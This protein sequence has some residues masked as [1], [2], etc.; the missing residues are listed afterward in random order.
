MINIPMNYFDHAASTSLYPEV[1]DTL[2]TSMRT[3]FAN[4]SALHLLGHDLAEKISL[5]KEN[6]LRVL[7]GHKNDS[8]I[9][10]SSAT[11]SNNTVIKGLSFEEGDVVVYCRADHPSV[12]A[13]VENLKGILLREIVLNENGT[14][15]LEL[16][17][18]LIDEKVKLVVIT[19]VNNQS[20]VFLDTAAMSSIAKSQSKAHVHIDAVQSFGKIHF[21]VTPD[22]D[23]VSFTSHKI[24]GPKGI[25]GLFLK[26]GHQVKPLLLGGGQESGVRSSTQAYPLISGFHQA[27]RM[28]TSGQKVSLEQVS[29]FS[30]MIKTHLEKTI[31]TIMMP[32][33]N[34][35]PYI[36]SFI[37][38]GISSDI[39]LRHLEMRE[40]YISSTSACSSRLS[41]IN[42]TLSAMNIS[43]R[44]HKNF[45][46]ISLGPKTTEK[47]VQNLLKEFVSV[48]DGVKHMQK[49]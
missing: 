44:Y 2:L 11:E 5:Y 15:D 26:N 14:V 45:L 38:P 40:V 31:P 8:F 32:F 10:T 16:F 36:V 6:F 41:G 7:G 9:F 23:S 12:T 28:A 27:M 42:P 43:E 17:K 22:I 20:G 35:S 30:E 47:E 46:R 49:R 39:I 21:K 18:T 34:T 29:K 4:P 37:L 24:G 48:W 1:L 3:D 25:A 13:P 19:S 33:T